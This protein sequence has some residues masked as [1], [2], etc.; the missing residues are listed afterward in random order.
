[1]KNFLDGSKPILLDGATGTNL[2]KAGMPSGVC[3]EAWIIDHPEA[4][5]N[6]QKSFAEAGSMAVYAPT[7]GANR[8]KLSRYGLSERTQELN[9]RLVTL[10]R[11]ACPELKVGG[12]LTSLGLFGPPAGDTDFESLYE[13][14]REQADC[15]AKAGVDFFTVETITSLRDARAAYLACRAVSKK[16]VIV[17]MTVDEKGKTM[18]GTDAVA[19]AVVLESMGVDAFGLNCSAGPEGLIP[20]LKKIREVCNLPLVCKPNAGLPRTENGKTTFDLT[21]EELASFI[22]TLAELGVLLYGGCCGTTPEH[23]AALS[24]AL[25]TVTVQ[26]FSQKELPLAGRQTLYRE[27]ELP[28]EFAPAEDLEDLVLDAEEDETVAVRIETE[29]D[30]EDLE[31][32]FFLL[33]NPLAIKAENPELLEKALRLYQGRAMIEA[34][35]DTTLL[36]STYGALKI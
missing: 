17:S 11:E 27:L 19:A 15:L 8:E 20:T 6:L 9:T 30:L 12:D 32:Y 34:D 23:I 4:L 2:A 7:F 3:P 24:K 36:E 22:P 26:R 10:S 14:Y 13:I 5:K 25:K 35:F 1:M 21:P 29:N 18:D 33:R 16:P 28:E 31:E